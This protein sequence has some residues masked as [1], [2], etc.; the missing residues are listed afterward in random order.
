MATSPVDKN[1]EFMQ[2]QFGTKVL[3]TDRAADKY[4]AQAAKHGT[5]RYRAWC[6]GK[7]GFDDYAERL[8]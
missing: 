7:G 5:D 1:S 4:L 8:H 3:I 2:E 6:G